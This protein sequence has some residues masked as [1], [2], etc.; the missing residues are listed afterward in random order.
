M[1]KKLSL[2]ADVFYKYYPQ[3][4]QI[5]FIKTKF[6]GNYVL[7]LTCPDYI[8]SLQSLLARQISLKTFK[9]VLSLKANQ[10]FTRL[11]EVLQRTELIPSESS[12][13]RLSLNRFKYW[14]MLFVGDYFKL[15][16]ESMLNEEFEVHA[17]V[18]EGGA[19]SPIGAQASGTYDSCLYECVYDSS[20]AN[21]GQGC[22]S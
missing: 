8:E 7:S 5:L 9:S 13:E 10:E 21:T 18:H 17:Q 20:W 11:M 2:M 16:L 12:I 14:D 1:R 6:E 22:A 15:Q 4:K 19:C 3:K